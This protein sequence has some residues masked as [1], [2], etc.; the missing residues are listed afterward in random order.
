[1]YEKLSTAT[2]YIQGLHPFVPKVGIVLGSGLGVFMECM[3]DPFQI[4]YEDIPFFKKTTVDGHKGRLILGNIHNVPCAILQ[5]RLHGYEGYHMNEVVFP[6]RTL[7]TLGVE[8][9]IL[10]NASGGI[11]RNFSLGDLV[12]IKD[13]INLMGR[14]PLVG[15]N[16]NELGPRFPDMTHTY[17][18]KLRSIFYKVA[19]ENQIQLKEG[20]Y[21]SLLGPTYETPAEIRMLSTLGAD[22][23][24]MSTAPEAIAAHH[25][26]IKVA[27]ISCISNMAAGITEK[28]LHHSH[29]EQEALKVMTTFSTLLSQAI[30]EIGKTA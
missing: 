5:G 6:V 30:D 23:V 19:E 15:P 25:L 18:R 7:A 10:T 8:T 9:L 20:V 27:G 2:Q 21:C 13:H 29:I 12:L 17:N 28:E 16:I 26:G 1:M 11:N 3:K 22:M 24:G 14:N 4:P